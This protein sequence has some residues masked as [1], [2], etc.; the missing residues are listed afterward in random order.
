VEIEVM[1]TDE[2]LIGSSTVLPKVGNGDP[3]HANERAC[4]LE[5]LIL[6]ESRVEVADGWMEWVGIDDIRLDL[7]GRRCCDVD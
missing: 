3:H 5:A 7:L 2:I 1:R 6:A 4:L